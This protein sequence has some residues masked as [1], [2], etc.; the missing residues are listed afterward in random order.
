MTS[1]IGKKK[2]DAPLFSF[3][4]KNLDPGNAEWAVTSKV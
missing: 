4:K 3:G 1:G 2:T